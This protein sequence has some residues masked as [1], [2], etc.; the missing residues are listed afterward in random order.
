MST[1]S[2][3]SP[4]PPGEP[5][6]QTTATATF[7]QLVDGDPLSSVLTLDERGSLDENV[8]SKLTQTL[9]EL[10]KN[11]HEAVTLRNQD[12]VAYGK[13]QFRSLSIMMTCN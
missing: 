3:T 11:L 6:P 13:I 10:G 4:P 12:R 8:R 1:L 5:L 7:A 2:T 9:V